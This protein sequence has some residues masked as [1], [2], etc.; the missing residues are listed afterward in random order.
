MAVE[1][2]I[3]FD[4]NEFADIELLESELRKVTTKVR[5][6][7]TTLANAEVTKNLRP[8]LSPKG[9]KRRRK[10][11][12]RKKSGKV[13]G[14]SEALRPD[15]LKPSEIEDDVFNIRGTYYR[16]VSPG[17]G[18]LEPVE[19]DKDYEF[20]EAFESAYNT[21]QNNYY[22]IMDQEVED[23]VRKVIG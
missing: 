5:G 10:R 3:T 2:D 20:N 1:L 19:Y 4:A 17:P 11:Y 21:I 6:R 8:I 18:G 14:G 13:F 9:L 15:L 16:R 7:L 12:N 23:A 22:T